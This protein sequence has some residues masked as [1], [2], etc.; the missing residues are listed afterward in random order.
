LLA[1]SRDAAGGLRARRL[2]S[3]CTMMHILTALESTALATWVRESNSLWAYPT[4][5]TL[6]TVGLGILVGAN[7]ALDFRLLGVAPRVPL[8]PLRQ[9]FPLMWLGFWINAVTG[10]MLFAADASTRGSTRLFVFKLGL[11]ALAVLVVKLTDRSVF[12]GAGPARISGGARALAA[13]SLVLWT[14]AIL[15]GRLMAYI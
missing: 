1:I 6:H 11:V 5:L 8:E 10:A 13:T 12:A 7:W 3:H 15:A 9:L 14:A 4:V 2:L